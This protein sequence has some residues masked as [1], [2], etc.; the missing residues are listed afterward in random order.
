MKINEVI[1]QKK[2]YN[3]SMHHAG[4]SRVTE[5]P[6]GTGQHGMCRNWFL[7]PVQCRDL[8]DHVTMQASI[9]TISSLALFFSLSCHPFI[10]A[11][12]CLY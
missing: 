11:E 8:L 5:W 3:N 1:I 4:R 7:R 12:V 2:T 6:P 10:D 9:Y